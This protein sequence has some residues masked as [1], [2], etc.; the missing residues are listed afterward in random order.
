MEE[1]IDKIINWVMVNRTPIKWSVIAFFLSII[2]L[3]IPG[4]LFYAPAY[5]CYWVLGLESITD[6]IHAENIWPM[7][8][9]MSVLASLFI[10]PAH[11]FIKAYIPYLIGWKHVLSLIVTIWLTGVLANILLIYYFSRLSMT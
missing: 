2:T 6:K 8:I 1:Y 3:G 10:V 7:L 5:F 11:L 9:L 4:S